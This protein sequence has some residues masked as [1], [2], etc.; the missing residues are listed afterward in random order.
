M[1]QL[2]FTIKGRQCREV[3][4]IP[5]TTA[6][7][8]YAQN[9]RSAI[10]LAVAQQRFVYSEFFPD[11]PNCIRFGETNME[12]CEI[13][14]LVE[15]NLKL[16]ERRGTLEASTIATQR[17]YFARQIKPAFGGMT[18][19]ELRASHLE[20]WV[21]E[22]GLKRSSAKSALACLRPVIKAAI[23]DGIIVVNP[24]SYIDWNK[25]IPKTERLASTKDK[26]DPLHENEIAAVLRAAGPEKTLFMFG[27]FTGMRVQELPLLKWENVDWRRNQILVEQA[28]GRGAEGEYQKLTKTDKPRFVTLLPPALAALREQRAISELHSEYIFLDHKTSKLYALQTVADRWRSTL[29]RAKIRFRPVKQMRHT[30]ASLMLTKGESEFWVA[31]QL[32]HAD[33]SML[34]DHYAK[35]IPEQSGAAYTPKNDWSLGENSTDSARAAR[36]DKKQH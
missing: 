27:L 7:I 1:L 21:V 31:D 33:L 23:A 24:I 22:S 30:F 14:Y 5:P 15:A 9:L 35:W 11:S 8:L 28:L 25:I 20:D 26:I 18:I 32:G 6:N 16:A 2:S 36:L 12:Q 34:R 17:R 10:K 4:D 19:T 29:R 3:L 13:G